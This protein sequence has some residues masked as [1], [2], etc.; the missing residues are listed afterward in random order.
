MLSF[1]LPSIVNLSLTIK[2][3]AI[4]FKAFKILWKFSLVANYDKPN[5]LRITQYWA[6]WP[7]M[8]RNNTIISSTQINFVSSNDVFSLIIMHNF[9][10]IYGYIMYTCWKI[11][12]SLFNAWCILSYPNLVIHYRVNGRSICSPQIITKY[13]F[14]TCINA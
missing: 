2:S 5:S 1:I 13:W 12:Q 14:S 11:S 4:E 8:Y 6:F 10:N 7:S 9:I 3:N